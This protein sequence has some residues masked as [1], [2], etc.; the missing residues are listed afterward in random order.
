[1]SDDWWIKIGLE[2][3]VQVNTESKMYCRCVNDNSDESPNS[4]VC[5]ICLGL[6][7]SLPV[8]NKKVLELAQMVSLGL[9]CRV[10]HISS[11]DRKN[12]FYPDLPKGYQITQYFQPL[13]QNG[14]IELSCKGEAFTIGINRLHLEEDTAKMIHAGRESLLDFNRS[15]IPLM[16]IVTE[17]DF[18]SADQAQ[19]F[20]VNLRDLVKWIGASKARMQ[21]GEMRCDAN[22]S[23]WEGE[24]QRGEIVEV[25]NL[26]SIRNVRDAIEFEYDRQ[27]ELVL[28][29][30][31]II[32]E[33]RGWNTVIS[34]T[35]SQR[36][37]EKV[38]DYRYFPEPDLPI[39]ELSESDL[40]EIKSK[41]PILPLVIKRQMR[42]QYGLSESAI[43]VFFQN[44]DLFYFFEKVI[45]ELMIWLVQKEIKIESIAKNEI[46][47]FNKVAGYVLTDLLPIVREKG[48]LSFIKMTPENY[49][50]LITLFYAKKINNQTM[51][52]I[53]P[54]MVKGG[55]GPLEVA[56]K[57]CWLQQDSSFD[58]E[59]VID[60]VLM[61]NE[62]QVLEYK[63]GKIQLLAYFV[64]QVMKK[65]NGMIDPNEARD[66]LNKKMSS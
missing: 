36:E 43:D 66:L 46:D 11:F 16:E 62:K 38:H 33:T 32:K 18:R 30:E 61:Q 21:H 22:I 2:V 20:L 31:K 6:P 45:S 63:S 4:R 29:G 1:M 60:E 10:N 51:K 13:A 58:L 3:H 40:M 14:K 52:K 23:L 44:V 26:N 7:G 8:L 37:K 34:E 5:P 24:E 42:D 54:E 55:L 9:N 19:I 48:G 25:K 15:G 57:N 53:L 59:K 17:P 65:T 35:I 27:K 49:A 47:I 39:I 64:G 28:R 41:M 12:Y 56:T 50:E